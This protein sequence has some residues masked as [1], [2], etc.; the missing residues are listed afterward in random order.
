M[1]DFIRNKNETKLW[2]DIFFLFHF[3]TTSFEICLIFKWNYRLYNLWLREHVENSRF[4]RKHLTS[5]AIIKG[6]GNDDPICEKVTQKLN[7]FIPLFIHLPL[8]IE[9]RNEYFFY[10]HRNFRI[11]CKLQVK[12]WKQTKNVCGAESF[13]V[14]SRVKYSLEQT[15][16]FNWSHKFGATNGEKNCKRH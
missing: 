3:L 11:E 5:I 13:G 15:E 9:R 2:R 6:H 16:C 14:S 7:F 1:W 8:I 12:T 4:N 10:T